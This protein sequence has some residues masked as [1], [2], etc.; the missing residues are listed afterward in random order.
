MAKKRDT[1]TYE[2]RQG[3]KVVYVGTTNDPE[4]RQNEHRDQGKKFGKMTITS[5][6]MTSEGAQKKESERLP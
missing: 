2:L 5:K 4:R 1:V 3:N 6:K